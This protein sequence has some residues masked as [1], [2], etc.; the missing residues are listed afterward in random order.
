MKRMIPKKIHISILEIC[1]SEREKEGK[2]Q[3]AVAAVYFSRQESSPIR[4]VGSRRLCSKVGEVVGVKKKS[5]GDSKKNIQ[6]WP[7]SK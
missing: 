6:W 5:V 4:M 1:I 2:V 7:S 3:S